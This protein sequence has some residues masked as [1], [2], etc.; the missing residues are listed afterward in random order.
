V[1]HLGNVFQ[2][3]SFAKKQGSPPVMLYA[4][5]NLSSTQEKPVRIIV[6]V[7][8]LLVPQ[9][10]SSKRHKSKGQRSPMWN[11][12]GFTGHSN[13]P[14]HLPTAWCEDLQTSQATTS[15]C[16]LAWVI[17]SRDAASRQ[18]LV[19]VAFYRTAMTLRWREHSALNFHHKAG[20]TVGGKIQ[21]VGYFTNPESSTYDVYWRL[22]TDCSWRSRTSTVS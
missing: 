5:S 10:M 12:L 22:R 2:Q 1:C 19:K 17:Q 9:S 21:R 6:S 16:L 11:P 18:F 3:A 8:V 4:S 13:Q 14:R 15:A 20:W 7:L